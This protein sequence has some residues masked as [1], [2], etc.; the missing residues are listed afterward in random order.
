MEIAA[1]P[2]NE[3]ERLE[4]LY[5]YQILD[6]DVEKEFDDLVHLAADICDTPIA[7]ISLVDPK[8]QWFKASFG[9]AAKETSRDIAFCSHAILQRDILEVEDTFL[10]KRFYDNPLVLDNPNIRFY[11]G[12]QLVTPEGFKLGTL[13]TISD[14]PKKL[15]DRQRQALV[16]IANEAIARMELHKQ[17]NQMQAMHQQLVEKSALLDAINQLQQLYIQKTPTQQLFSQM[18][19]T[20]LDITK[21]EYGFIGQVLLDE[22]QKPYLKIRAISNL[23]WNADMQKFLAEHAPEGME[24]RSMNTLIGEVLLKREVVISDDPENDTRAGG[25]PEGHPKLSNFAGI[26]LKVSEH[27]VG[28]AGIANRE[29]G[30]SETLLE[31][32]APFLA[33]CAQLTSSYSQQSF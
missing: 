11:A 4:A 26:P 28:I 17:I 7:L 29:G 3:Q 12:A 9:L 16:I 2:E 10:D 30:Y 31:K 15:T 32:I 23:S 13:C 27:F 5:A 25:V 21:A 18:L 24:F 33:T 14:K 8:R 6:T 22:A 1:I 20:L 19:S